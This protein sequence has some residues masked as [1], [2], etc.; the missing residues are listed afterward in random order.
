MATVIQ[1][2]VWYDC[3][4]KL[5]FSFQQNIVTVSDDAD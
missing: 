4:D 1:N 5:S 3:R 2:N